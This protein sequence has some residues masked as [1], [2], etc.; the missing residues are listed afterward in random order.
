MVQTDLDARLSAIIAPVVAAMGFDL[1]RVMLSGQ[2]GS[3]TLQVMAEDPATGQLTIDQCA[4]LSRA[5]DQPLDEADPIAGEYHLEV[6][7]PGIDRPL[8]RPGD[9]AKWAGHEAKMALEPQVDG[10]ARAT[11][12]IVGL[13][14]DDVL[15]TT[16]VGLALRLPLANIKQAK[17][18]LTDRLIAESKPLDPTGADEIIES[19]AAADNDNETPDNIHSED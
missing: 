7:S 12:T 18:V 1:V 10:R 17:L 16:K 13:E 11:G 14:G 5:L 15:L 8:T 19:S 6:S 9:W 2:P 4:K 3:L